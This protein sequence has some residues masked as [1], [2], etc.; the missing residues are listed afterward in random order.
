MSAHVNW[1]TLNDY[2]DGRLTSTAGSE[3]AQHIEACEEC[4]RTLARLRAVLA[5]ARA[6]AGAVEPPA[7]V[8]ESIRAEIDLRKVVP[9]P[10]AAKAPRRSPW[11]RVAA[12]IA[13][14]AASSAAT[15]AIMNRTKTPGVTAV[16][17][18]DSP[19]V[20]VVPASVRAIEEDYAE[21]VRSLTAALDSSRAKL[22][23]ETMEVVE[24]SLRIIDDAI[25]EAREALVRDPAS[26]HL[27]GMLSKNYQQKVDL[28]RRASARAS[29]T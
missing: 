7:G 8:W 16:T 26:V 3:V 21:A 18:I 1:E 11:L 10:G 12:V 25:A 14:I 20:S 29:T 15:V 19:A 23:P 17:P 9:I 22:A 13:I 5:S 27:R 2:A 4:R 28:L 24:R 6:S